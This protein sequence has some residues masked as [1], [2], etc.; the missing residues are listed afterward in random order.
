MGSGTGAPGGS[1]FKLDRM[2]CIIKE[3]SKTPL[4]SIVVKIVAVG[5]AI[6]KR[7]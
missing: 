5:A 1:G 7:D 4:T 3:S 6:S 2:L